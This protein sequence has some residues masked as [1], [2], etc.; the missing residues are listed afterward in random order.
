MSVTGELRKVYR[1]VFPED[2]GRYID[3]VFEHKYGEENAIWH[4]EGSR[5]VSHLFYV[6]RKL[7]IRGKA[8]DCP[9]IVAVGTL[10]EYRRRGFAELLMYRCFEELKGKGYALCTLHPFRHS[11]YQKFGFVTYIKVRVHTISFS[12]E[13]GFDLADIGEGDML[14]VKRLYDSFMTPYNGY[15][16]RDLEET[17]RRFEEFKSYSSCKFILKEGKPIGYVYFDDGFA[18]EYCG[19]WQAV[20]RIA[21]LNGRKVCLPI[22]SSLGEPTDFTMLKVLDRGRLLAIFG[23]DALLGALSDEQLVRALTGS[24][25]QFGTELPEAVA[26]KYFNLTNFVFD[27][28]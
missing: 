17:R 24:W 7:K 19:P 12:G 16:V 13:D 9:Y 26:G 28:Y 21:E 8:I 20:D 23:N 25:G 1:T 15:A 11:F 5:I 22:D 18:E 4:E 10:P 6:D 2:E 27:K 14:L 3:Y